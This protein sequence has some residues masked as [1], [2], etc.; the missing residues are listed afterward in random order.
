MIIERKLEES[1]PDFTAGWQA[2]IDFLALEREKIAQE[3]KN[4]PTDL[5]FLDG[6]SHAWSALHV[7]SL[8]LS[9]TQASSEIQDLV[10]YLTE[11]GN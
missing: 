6:V 10:A 5:R 11:E 8:E 4:D 3:Q 7:S 2:A 9:S 1:S